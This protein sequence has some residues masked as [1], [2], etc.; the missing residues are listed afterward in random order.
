M[1]RSVSCLVIVMVVATLGV[2]SAW[3][4]DYYVARENPKASDSNPGSETLPWATISRSIGVIQP[5]DT[6]HLGPGTY[7]E[8][9]IMTSRPRSLF[10]KNYPANATGQSYDKMIRFVA[11]EP[12]KTIIK[13]SDVVTGWKRSADHLWVKENWSHNSQMVFANGKILQQIAG[14]MSK[15]MSA[16]VVAGAKGPHNNKWLGRVGDGREDMTPGSFYVDLENK[17]LYVWLKENQ[18]PNKLLIEA[19]VRP[20][21]FFARGINYL[22]ISG[23]T[24]MHSNGSAD[25]NWGAFMLGKVSHCIVENVQVKWCDSIGFHVLGD[26]LTIRNS[27]FNHNGNSGVSAKGWGHRWIDNE[28]SYNN[29]RK[30]NYHWHAGGMKMIPFANDTVISGHTAAYNYGT[31]IWFDT[32]NSN[33]TIR[34]SLVHD[35]AWHGIFYEISEHAIIKNNRVYNNGA[36]GIYIAQSSNCNILYNLVYANGMT[37]IVVMGSGKR[38]NPNYGEGPNNALPARNNTVVGNILMDNSNPQRIKSKFEFDGDGKLRSHWPELILPNPNIPGNEGNRSDYNLFY[39][40]DDRPIPFWRGWGSHK[41]ISSDLVQWQT[42]HDQHSIIAKPLFVD[43]KAFDFHP[44]PGSP[45]IGLAR[46]QMSVRFDADERIRKIVSTFTVIKKKAK[47]V[48]IKIPYHTAGPYDP[49]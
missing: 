6:V 7:R 42:M 49:K 14:V 25:T 18:D 8:Q 30:F 28:T 23:L 29:W 3:A 35:N 39:R 1:N 27:K 32:W 37:G 13:G 41:L 15:A 43:L 24:M 12:G 47:K 31:G 2:R 48:K 38:I 5:G 26:N 36:Y 20:F 21:C 16:P 46:P 19:S 34:N 10:G 9:V 11:E 44:A 40:S 17:K 22:F 45:A 4:R 33:V